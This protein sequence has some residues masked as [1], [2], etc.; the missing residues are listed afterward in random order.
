MIIFT[1]NQQLLKKKKKDSVDNFI[2]KDSKNVQRGK[3]RPWLKTAAVRQQNKRGGS[4]RKKAAE[5]D[6]E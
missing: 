3:K 5:I 1:V 4:G 6:A 2:N